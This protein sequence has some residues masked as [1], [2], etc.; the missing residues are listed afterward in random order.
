MKKIFYAA[1]LLLFSHQI[2]AQQTAIYT[3]AEAGYRLGLELFNKQKYGA[4]QKEFQ[5]IIE[6]KKQIADESRT[7]AE[8]FIAFCAAELANKDA[9]YLLLHFIEDHPESP[10]YA[11]AVLE[12]STY[13]Y[14]QKQY[15]KAIAWFEKTDKSLLNADQLPEYQF[16]LGYSYYMTNDYEKATKAFNEVKDSDSKYASAATYY[17]AHMAYVNK[18]YETALKN[19]LKLKDSEA[20]AP[21]VP[22]YI[23]QIYFFQGKH[24]ELLKYAPA[25]I[26][27]ANLKNGLEIGRM[28]GESY[29]RKG[30]Y[31]EAIPYLVDYEKNSS[32]AGRTDF[33]QLGYCYYRT[34]DCDKA[35]PYFQR[36]T[37]KEDSIAQNAYYHLADCFLKKGNKKSARSS[38]QSA[39]RITSDDYIREESQF[40]YAKLSY[41]LSF[42]SVAIEAFRN[43]I[44]TFPQSDHVNEA[45]EM[46]VDIYATTKNF[47]D[48]LTAIENI[49]EQ[50]PNMKAAYQK[51]AY[52][53]AVEFYMD[54]KPN[55]AIGLFNVS[56]NNPSDQ[57]LVAAARYWKGEAFYKLNKY[58]NAIQSYTDFLFTPSAVL[59]KNYNLTNYNIGY[60]YFKKENYG[61]AQTWFRKYIK[62]KAQTDDARYNDALLRIAD[63][64]FM[65]KDQNN[66]LDYYNMAIEN[67]SK[68]SDYALFQ[69]AV[70]FGI[71]NRLKEKVI[72]LEKIFTQYPKSVYY[73]DA[74][75]ESGN[76]SMI[77]GD[78]EKA[79]MH[80]TKLINDFPSSS[81]VKKA[82]L[83]EA[84]VYFNNH[85]DEKA[86]S[87]YKNVI[88]KYPG[89][90]ESREALAQLKNVAV[91]QNKVDEYLTYVKTIPNADVSLAGQDSLVYESAELRYTQ[92]NCDYA[93]RDLDSYLQKYPEGFFR[94]NANYYKADCQF[95]NKLYEQALTG[96][97]Y[98]IDQPKSSFT[99]KSL[100]NAAIIHFRMKVY[101]K[102]LEEFERL[103]A[104]A[105]VKDNIM[106]AQ[107][108]LMRCNFM[109]NQYDKA[110]SNAEKIIASQDADK[111]LVNEAH[112]L[113]GKSAL[114][115]NDFETAKAELTIVSKR[116]NSEMTAESRY[117]LALIEYLLGNFKASE[118]IIQ[119]IQKLV[120]SYDYWV[121]KGFILWGDDFIAL[122]DTFQ[123]K[124]T[125]KSI[126]ENYE[127]NASDPDD[128]KTIA[129]QKLDAILSA[130]EIRNKQMIEQKIKMNPA[131]RDST[132]E[133]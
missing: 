22:Y 26:D 7:N 88:E 129:K 18:N 109:L 11:A 20:F 66:A 107:S 126:A 86:K 81:Y 65:L 53:R 104:T 75:Y 38:F 58:D 19:F 69:K 33:Y 112:L 118:K 29:Y 12:L 34:N 56:L 76:A 5:K 35:I 36:V 50:S 30:S 119:D 103:E 41:E 101:D 60:S 114:A 44:K 45:N 79:Q 77:A 1:L 124:E 17:Y 91:S 9:Q 10:K 123:A 113:K 115:K 72:T 51:V 100:L 4:A 54:N 16:R 120:P 59:M 40:N 3:D 31:K 96:Y 48:A 131:N 99:E 43:F 63:S 117:D 74:L 64:F 14:R 132:G 55:D 97:R 24:D 83:G 37:D 49:K 71:Q 39:A 47:K 105:E 2:V 92:G 67:K 122:K 23:T 111:D 116:T 98:V 110:I 27:S 87:A 68:S 21:V 133:N 15:K 108:G 6:S 28:V 93:I 121:A 73:D 52:Y 32:A 127:K 70:I 78:N 25:V 106:A 94:V 90:T 57:K 130:E 13:F 84:L 85:E 102:A 128:L 89:T 125:Y 46:L 95:R 8:F 61:D 62:E 80:F 82:M 42:Q